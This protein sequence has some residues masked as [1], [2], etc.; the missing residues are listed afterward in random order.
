[1]VVRSIG[2]L[3]HLPFAE[4]RA[5]R[6]AEAFASAEHYREIPDA[7][8]VPPQPRLPRSL[9]FL[10]QYIAQEIIG[11]EESASRWSTRDTAYRAAAARA[12]E[13]AGR[14]FIDA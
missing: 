10:A 5:T 6:P 7:T 1:V 2:A 3:S 12:D 13:T 4:A 9:P 14:I 8:I 11:P